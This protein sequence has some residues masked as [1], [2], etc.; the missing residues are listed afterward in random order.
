MVYQGVG[1]L[2]GK[3][4]AGVV[5]TDQPFAHGQSFYTGGCYHITGAGIYKDLPV[6][7]LDQK[8]YEP[9]CRDLDGLKQL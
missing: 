2:R 5:S 6:G 9:N 3:L 1:E 7:E 4:I 8:R